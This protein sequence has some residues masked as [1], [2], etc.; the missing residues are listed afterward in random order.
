MPHGSRVSTLPHTWHS[1]SVPCT[2]VSAWTS[3]TSAVSR[4]L[5]NH[6]TARRAE[7]GPRPGRR[8]RADARVSISCDAI[9]R[10]LS[11]RPELVAL[12]QAQ[13]ELTGVIPLV[14]SLSNHENA[15][16]RQLGGRKQGYARS[17]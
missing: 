14:V 17:L 16:C 2:A 12:R 1:T 10:P 13:G 7:R 8:A 6:S 5:T 15:R 3:C 4:R 11:A 9:R